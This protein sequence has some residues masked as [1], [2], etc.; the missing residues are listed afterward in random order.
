MTKTSK[1][2]CLVQGFKEVLSFGQNITDDYDCPLLMLNNDV[3]DVLVT[4]LSSSI[5]VVHCCTTTCGFF[6]EQSHRV[7]E[8]ETVDSNR[9]VFRHDLTNRMYCLN[10]YCM[11]SS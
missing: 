7:I 6:E 2:V 5:S 11:N 10:I 8:R 1:P 4:Q 9:L 3:F